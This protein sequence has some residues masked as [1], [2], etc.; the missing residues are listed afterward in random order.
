[1]LCS[2]KRKGEPAALTPAKALKAS[3]ALLMRTPT[4]DAAWVTKYQAVTERLKTKESTIQA[5]A[6]AKEDVGAEDATQ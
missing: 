4:D 5:G 2:H 1:L 6:S 3:A